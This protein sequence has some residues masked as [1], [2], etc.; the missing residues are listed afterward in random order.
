MGLS[1]AAELLCSWKASCWHAFGYNQVAP[2][3]VEH[4]QLQRL[5]CLHT[6]SHTC[7]CTYCTVCT[8]A[9]SSLVSLVSNSSKAYQLSWKSEDCQGRNT[10]AFQIF[11]STNRD[12]GPQVMVCPERG[13]LGSLIHNETV[14]LDNEMVVGIMKDVAMGMKFLHFSKIPTQDEELTPARVLLDSN[15]RAQLMH[16]QLYLV[17]NHASQMISLCVAVCFPRPPAPQFPTLPP[18]PSVAACVQ[19]LHGPAYCLALQVHAC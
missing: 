12:T 19:G 11:V 8:N 1:A 3:I 17:C 2:A 14:E 5:C 16:F 13:A 7:Q 4:L 10:C 6:A 9:L 15:Y 18:L